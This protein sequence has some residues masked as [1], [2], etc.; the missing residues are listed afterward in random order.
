MG[1]IEKGIVA[2]FF[3]KRCSK[4]HRYGWS[5]TM[6]DDPGCAICAKAQIAVAQE[7]E[8]DPVEALIRKGMF[9]TK[10]CRNDV[11]QLALTAW[12][13]AGCPEPGE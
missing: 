1:R 11:L 10:R 3:D 12:I 13:A 6:A 7:E 8:R 2:G 4:G 5:G 9:Q